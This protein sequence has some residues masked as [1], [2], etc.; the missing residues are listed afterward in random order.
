M[1]AQALSR[2]P[3]MAFGM[4]SLVLGFLALLLFFLPILTIPIAVCG[5][6]CGIAGL[7]FALAAPGYSLRWALGGTALSLVA[8]GVGFAVLYA[9]EGYH[10]QLRQ[11]TPWQPPRD[12]PFVAPPG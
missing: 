10:L 7:G 12:R 1:N 4:T 11:P 5:L 8:L 3:L 6:A 2:A 9:P